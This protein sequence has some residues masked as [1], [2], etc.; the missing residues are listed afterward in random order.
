MNARNLRYAARAL[1]LCGIFV[2]SGCSYLPVLA[3][4][5]PIGAADKATI[6][7]SIAL[8]LIVAIPVFVLTAFVVWRYRASRRATYTPDWSHSRRLEIVVWVVPAIIVV[9]LGGLVWSTTH[10][11]SPY[12][13]IASAAK[14]L[15]IDVVALDW[16][17]LFIYPDQHI[18]S[19]N[20]LVIPAGVPVSF[21]ITSNTV[22]SSFFIPRLG[23][24]IYAMPGMRTKLHLLADAPGTYV[25][26]N[27][28]FSGAGYASMHFQTIATTPTDFATWVQHMRGGHQ[29]LDPAAWRQLQ[30]PVR[31]GPVISYSS[32]QPGL[33]DRIIDKFMTAK[34][35]PAKPHA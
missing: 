28:Q 8:M 19:V 24:Q 23:S 10:R 29:A 1:S 5:G 6:L 21:R 4:R 11:I 27:Y 17:W 35:M 12:K 18:A 14:P 9:A 7:T 25:G 22:T 33:F 30:K 32:V 16:R 26:R 31:G 20:K 3:P 34:T 2:L 15:P 13:A